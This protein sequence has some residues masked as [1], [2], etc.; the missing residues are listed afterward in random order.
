MVRAN[1]H[2]EPFVRS[3]VRAGIPYQFF[4]PGTLYKQ[5]EVKDLIAYLK[6][7]YNLEDSPSLF[8]LLYMDIYSVDKKDVSLLL[9]FSKKINQSLFQA[10][11]IYLFDRSEFEIY[12]NIYRY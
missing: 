10:M 8:R 1:N 2:S 11:E 6:V 9:T 3:L 4:G 5:P 7:L 12:K